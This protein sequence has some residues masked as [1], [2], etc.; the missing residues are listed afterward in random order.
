[1]GT[2]YKDLKPGSAQSVH[3]PVSSK[4]LPA[5]LPRATALGGSGGGGQG[6]HH[7]PLV[8]GL[9]EYPGSLLGPWAVYE[10]VGLG[11]EVHFMCL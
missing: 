2:C 10:L 6:S 1:M 9:S 7:L 11:G 4:S 5:L 3:T 8:A